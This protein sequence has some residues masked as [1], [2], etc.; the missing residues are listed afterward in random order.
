[1]RAL[2]IPHPQRD[3]SAVVT[4]QVTAECGA[5]VFTEGRWIL[6]GYKFADAAAPV[7]FRLPFSVGADLPPAARTIETRILTPGDI[8]FRILSLSVTAKSENQESNWFPY[9][10]VGPCGIHSGAEVKSIKDRVGLIARTP[11]MAM[12]P[13]HYKLLP[14]IPIDGVES[15][16]QGI[17][18]FEVWSGSDL[19][20]I[21][22]VK[23]GSNQLLEFDVAD[24]FSRRA[25]ELRVRATL[26]S[27]LSIRGV[28][29]EKVS[30]S[31]DPAWRKRLARTLH[32]YRM[33]R[34]RALL[35]NPK[36]FASFSKLL[37]LIAARIIRRIH[38]PMK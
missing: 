11:S 12:V 31:I 37:S 1:M 28:V 21:E 33:A 34:V 30:D 19:I 16:H 4:G 15:H 38:G 32:Q 18:T 27:Q 23:P 10:T 8:S 9:L 5:R 24:D 22:M 36:D 6:S 17:V 3:E 7:E 14:D 25:I 35:R 13:G 29:V 2:I 26:P 20:A